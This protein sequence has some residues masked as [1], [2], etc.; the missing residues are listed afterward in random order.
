MAARRYQDSIPSIA[1][2]SYAIE[3]IH[4]NIDPSQ[5]SSVGGIGDRSPDLSL[6]GKQVKRED[7]EQGGYTLP[8]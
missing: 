3:A 7:Q 2:G 5:R 4:N 8:E 6:L 1:A